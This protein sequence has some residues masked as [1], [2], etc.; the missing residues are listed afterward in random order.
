MPDHI[1]GVLV[2]NRPASRPDQLAPVFGPQSGNLV[3][4]VRGFKVGVKAWATRNQV[5]FAWQARY[6]DRIIRHEVELEKIRRYIQ[7][8]P[9]RWEIDKENDAEI[10]C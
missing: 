10:F 9:N 5:P 4:V 6:F 1:H 7:D 8:N 2:F 3:A